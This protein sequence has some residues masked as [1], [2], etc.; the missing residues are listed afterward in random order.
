MTPRNTAASATNKL[1]T[2]GPNKESSNP[3]CHKKQKLSKTS[4]LP[5][6]SSVLYTDAVYYA[7]QHMQMLNN[8]G[9]DSTLIAIF[10]ILNRKI[11]A[12]QH[13]ALCLKIYRKIKRSTD[14][15]LYTEQKLEALLKL[16]DI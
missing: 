12:K 8:I 1:P 9:K 7:E 14:Y 6:A 3:P 5:H 16:K 4:D 2:V 10:H 13:I 15:P 11:I